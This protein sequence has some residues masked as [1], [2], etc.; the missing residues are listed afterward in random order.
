MRFLSYMRVAFE[1]SIYRSLEYRWG[2]AIQYLLDM[3]WYAV[4][5]ALLRT[6]YEYVPEV[7]G[8][9][10][11]E[12]YIFLGFLYALDAFNMIFFEAGLKHFTDLIRGGTLDFYLLKPMS[13]LFQI[14]VVRV[15]L[16][17]FF[18]LVFTIA[19]W[20]YVFIEF[21][22]SYPP[23][24]WLLA[25]VLFANGIL[26]NITFRLSIASAA[27]WTT[28]GGTINWLFHELM[29]FGSKPESVYPRDARVA[30]STFVP[31]LLINAWP[32]MALVREPSA[33]ELLYPFAVSAF[34]VL[35]LGF[36]WK[37]GVRRYEGLS[38]Q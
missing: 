32:V 15:N 3:I 13:T 36:I 30:L 7:G 1:M 25:I 12:A 14:S 23:E 33:A 31:V 10:L 22:P 11:Q 21:N 6:A 9:S 28:E 37:R 38:F 29:R 20:I 5:F 35:L 24:R 26:I 19:F 16:S 27:F 17:G 8:Y 34:S 18:N 4:Q 2:V